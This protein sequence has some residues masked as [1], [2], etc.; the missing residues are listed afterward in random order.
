[1]DAVIDAFRRAEQITKTKSISQKN[2]S[3]VLV[4]VNSA[5]AQI[6]AEAPPRVVEL[7]SGSAKAYKL[8][9]RYWQCDQKAPGSSQA[10]CRD[11]Q[12]EEAIA[13]FPHIRRNITRRLIIR[14]NPPAHI[15]SVISKKNVV[16][17][18]LMQAELNRVD[19][20]L[21]LTGKV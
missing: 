6:P 4:E 2:Y 1:M 9:F 20:H 5:V 15:S 8:A 16:Q 19:A 13:S 10:S 11:D 21:I 3:L 7:L 18:L 17:L 12:L 14:P